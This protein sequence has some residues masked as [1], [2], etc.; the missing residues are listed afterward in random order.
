MTPKQEFS[1]TQ[2]SKV[3]PQTF[4]R[5]Q[6]LSLESGHE[7]PS[8]MSRFY[9]QKMTEKAFYLKGSTEFLKN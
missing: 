4:A 8:V 1:R 3:V 6:W 7:I 9:M 2:T 5:L